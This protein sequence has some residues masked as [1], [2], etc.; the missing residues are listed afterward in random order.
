M[1]E[2]QG[3]VEKERA[4]MFPIDTGEGNANRDA[5]LNLFAK[6]QCY[7]YLIDKSGFR[8]NMQVDNAIALFDPQTASRKR[9]Q[10]AR[11]AQ[12]P[13]ARCCTASGR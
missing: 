4:G 1:C 13:M 2:E 7:L 3:R 8:D 5:L 10:G 11:A 12:K 9:A 6:K